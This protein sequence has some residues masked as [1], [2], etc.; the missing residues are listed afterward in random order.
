MSHIARYDVEDLPPLKI[1]IPLSFQHVFAMFG[2]TILV[3]LLTG[4]NPAIAL[5]SSG[6]GTLLYIAVTQAKVP[7]YLGS[8]FAFIPPIIA[9]SAAFG[10]E[11]A[12]GAGFVVGIFYVIVAGIIRA[13]G[14][15]WLDHILPPVVI[16]A[17]IMVIGL[18]LAPIAMEMS[19]Y[20]NADPSLGYRWEYFLTAAVT[21]GIGV[22]CSIFLKGFFTVVPVLIAIVGGYLF[23][24]VFGLFFPELA[25]ID[26]DT[27]AAAP[28]FGLPE[29]TAPKFG[30]VPIV[31]FLFVSLATIAEHLGD[32]LVMGTVAGRD[33]YKDPGI[34]RTLIG[35][36]IATSFASL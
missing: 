26:F 18:T 27:V 20:P 13:F 22:I 25:L 23:A 2:A 29:F 4:L 30:L 19:M 3:P 12:L 10:I 36:G 7:A 32:T 5:F 31:T 11:Y 34:H 35:D 28:W 24:V 1:W 33:F 8:S 6:V 9:V 16:G 21:L 14:R 17:I 15:N